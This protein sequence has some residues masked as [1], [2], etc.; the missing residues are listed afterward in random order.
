MH[1]SAEQERRIHEE[2]AIMRSGEAADVSLC[3]YKSLSCVRCCL[4]HIGGDPYMEKEDAYLGPHGVLMKFRNI[5]PLKAPKMDASQYEDSLPDVGRTEMERRFSERRMLFLAVYDGAQPK[6][7]LRRY[8]DKAQENERYQYKPTESSGPASMFLGGSVPRHLGNG[9]L[10]ECQLL[11][12]LDGRSAV[13]CMAHPLAGMSRGY[14]GRDQVGF[15]SNTGCCRNVGCEASREFPFLSASA[16]KV[17]N[18]AVFGMSWYE[19]SRH[20]TSV[21]V[22]YLRSYDWI[23]QKLDEKGILDSMALEQTV[24]FT[25]GLYGDWPLRRLPGKLQDGAVSDADRLLAHDIL[26]TDRPLAERIMHIALDSWFLRDCFDA[27]L[28]QAEAFVEGRLEVLG[29]G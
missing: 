9:E 8:M 22:Y 19:Y 20:A 27:Q 25:N 24:G 1:Y 13:G 5:D 14:D 3:Q 18:K 21:L 4:P 15:F 28:R 6:Q 17:F 29:A 23:L 7:S 26:S 12:F 10:P 11:G 2:Q 16:L